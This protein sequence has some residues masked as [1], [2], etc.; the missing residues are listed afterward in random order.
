MPTIIT[1][2]PRIEAGGDSLVSAKKANE[3]IDAINAIRAAM[4]T[5][6]TNVGK[7]SV[8]GSQFILDLSQFDQR[9]QAVEAQSG[10]DSTNITLLQNNVTILQNNVSVLQNNVTTIN[11]RLNNVTINGSGS[12]AGNNITLT[13][14]INI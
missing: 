10:S 6:N 4:I 11:N 14:N 7:F 13:V 3:L 12:C 1:N 9:L 2:I 5:P 8:S